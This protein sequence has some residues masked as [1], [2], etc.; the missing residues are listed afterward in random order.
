MILFT[1]HRAQS[2]LRRFYHPGGLTGQTAAD[3]AD[4]EPDAATPF[5]K[6][7]SLCFTVLREGNLISVLKPFGHNCFKNVIR[8]RF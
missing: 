8:G 7:P 1:N 6:E 3:S 4:P 5:T 2:D